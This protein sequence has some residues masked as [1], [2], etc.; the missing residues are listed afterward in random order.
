MKNKVNLMGRLGSDPELRNISADTVVCKAT[1]ATSEKYK[2]KSGEVKEETQWHTL[3]LWGK[4]AEVFAKYLKK[5]SKVDIEGKII[6]DKY[7]KDG[8]KKTFTKIRVQSF[9]FLD[10]KTGSEDVGDLPF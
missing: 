8:E 1:I 3:E 2:D 6:Y 9:T 4:Q 7:E 10:S 5:G